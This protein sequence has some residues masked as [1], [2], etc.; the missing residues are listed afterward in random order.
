MD[1]IVSGVI[2]LRSVFGLLLGSRRIFVVSFFLHK[3]SKIIHLFAYISSR[4]R[5]RERDERGKKREC[6]VYM[7]TFFL[8]KYIAYMT[9]SFSL[10]VSL[11]LRYR[12]EKKRILCIVESS[13]I[14][15]FLAPSHE[16]TL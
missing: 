1:S 3:N 8:E 16:H 15:D 11:I 4:Q 6:A 12:Y 13:S 5:E 9:L 7:Y 14:R 2:W 10:K